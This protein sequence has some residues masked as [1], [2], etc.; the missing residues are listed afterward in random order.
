MVPVIDCLCLAII[1]NGVTV[2]PVILRDECRSK[3]RCNAALSRFCHK[4][5]LPKDCCRVHILGVVCASVRMALCVCVCVCV[6]V[7]Y[8]Y[9]SVCVCARVHACVCVVYV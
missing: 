2:N 1:Q 8:A 3:S 5:W 7:C 9:V 6:C 4:F